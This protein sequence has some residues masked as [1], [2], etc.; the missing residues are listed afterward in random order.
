MR[1]QRGNQG[2]LQTLWKSQAISSPSMELRM[3]PRVAH[4]YA[5]EGGLRMDVVQVI[6][7]EHAKTSNLFE[8]LA[9][10]SDSALKT[11]GRLFDQLKHG[12]EAHQRAMQDVVYPILLQHVE[13]QNL[14]PQLREQNDRARIID[15]LERTPKDHEDFLTKVK[16]LR[17]SVEQHL[18]NEEREILPAVKKVIS[19]DQIEELA[20]R[21]AA[22]TREERENAEERAEGATSASAA[23]AAA[24]TATVAGPIQFV[25]VG[26]QALQAGQKL[27]QDNRLAVEDLQKLIAVP[28]ATT[29]AVQEVQ[30]VWVDC[31]QRVMQT[32]V[33]G[34]QE[35]ARSRS[36]GEAAELQG[37]IIRQN[38]N[39]WI[40][41]TAE[42]FRIAQRVLSD[43]LDQLKEQTDRRK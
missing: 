25:E 41:G 4:A 9:D 20:R 13:T 27:M 14:L 43:A 37:G 29:R 28:T 17:R 5:K 30:Q 40:E 11:R 36:V 32:N 39:S 31:L 26:A 15:E 42:S 12:L 35:I 1:D 18:R 3:A 6:K 24:M 34:M 33:Q 38:V 7:R 2:H 22:E 8:K 19:K 10:T 21:I 23:T 16:Q